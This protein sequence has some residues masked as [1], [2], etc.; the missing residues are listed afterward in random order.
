M[1]RLLWPCGDI[2]IETK[3]TIIVRRSIYAEARTISNFIQEL[4]GVI[5]W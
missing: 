5:I 1:G 3:I 4:R 2:Y